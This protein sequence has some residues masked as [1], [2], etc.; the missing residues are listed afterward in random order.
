MV[1]NRKP[2]RA[3]TELKDKFNSE[4]HKDHELNFNEEKLSDKNRQLIKNRIVQ[5]EKDKS[6][7]IYYIS[8]VVFIIL[9]FVLKYIIE[10]ILYQN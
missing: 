9:I 10:R 8:I 2:K 1:F 4:V 3:F 5:E 6:I 7:K